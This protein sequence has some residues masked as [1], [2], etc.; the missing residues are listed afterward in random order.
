MILEDIGSLLLRVAMGLLFL[1][2]AHGCSRDEAARRHAVADTA[3]VFKWR[4]E[5]FASIS[6]FMAAAAGLS[7][8]LGIFPRI[9]AL[10]MAVY[11]VPAAM[12]HF[13]L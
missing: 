8:L 3:L 11:L 10:A 9:G 7:V 2:C 13:A 1:A 6:V 12:I 5:L 4:P